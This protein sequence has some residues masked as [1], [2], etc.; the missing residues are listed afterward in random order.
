MDLKQYLKAKRDL[1]DGF[2]YSATPAADKYPASLHGSMRYS[3]EAG[4]KRVRPVLALAAA[5]AVKG[6]DASGVPGLLAAASSLELIHT[7]SLIHDDLPAMDD[8]DLRRGKPTNHKV[9]GEAMAILAGDALLTHAF[10]LLTDPAHT[11]GTEPR[12]LVS[13]IR[14]VAV[15]SGSHGMV[16]GQAV[17]IES[18]GEDKQV[19]FATLEYI[20]VHK[21]GALI[22]ASVRVGAFAAGA[23]AAQLAALTRYGMDVGLAFQVADD[24][25]DIEGDQAEIGKDVGSDVARG[26][27]TYPAFVGLEESK[28]RAREL[29]DSAVEALST[30][31]PSA[32]PLREIARY[33][34]SRRS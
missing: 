23:D 16:G 34:V 18:E 3:L 15:G 17:D 19:D 21:T 13:I 12:A 33:I 25:L 11:G 20:H 5:E 31:G 2:L 28:R 24:I 9:W 4:G 29:A 8:D 1:V 10:E 6:G 32:D 14:E 26:K 7:Y 22:R 30:F 27:K